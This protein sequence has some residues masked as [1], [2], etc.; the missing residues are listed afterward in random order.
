MRNVEELTQTKR[1]NI[2]SERLMLESFERFCKQGAGKGVVE[3]HCIFGH[4]TK[5]M[6]FE[7][8][9]TIDEIKY[10]VRCEAKVATQLVS[11]KFTG[12]ESNAVHK[13]F[14]LILAGRSV[15]G[16]KAMAESPDRIVYGLMIPSRDVAYFKRRYSQILRDW[17]KFGSTF[18]ARYVLVFDE[19]QSELSIFEWENAWVEGQTPTLIIT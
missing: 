15:P 7:A 10:L 18:S 19:V 1:D 4:S 5:E 6:D 14:G 3:L 9:I 12:D 13:V 11:N 8:S 2:P 16:C 17:Q